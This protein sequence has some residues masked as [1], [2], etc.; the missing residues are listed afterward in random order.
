MKRFYF[1]AVLLLSAT[2]SLH[3]QREQTAEGHAVITQGDDM[4]PNQAREHV[5]EQAKFDAINKTFGSNI[6]HST[7]SMTQDENGQGTSSFFQIGESDLRGTWVKDLDQRVENRVENGQTV[8][9]AWVKGKVRELKRAVVEFK[10]QLLANGIDERYAT[11]QLRDGDA[12]YVR[13]RSPVK[14]YLMLF[15]ADDQG[16]VTLCLPEEGRDYCEIKANQWFLFHHNPN[17]PQEHW[18]ATIPAGRSS[19][20]D[21]LYIVFSPN[22]IFPPGTEQ[23]DGKDLKRYKEKLKPMQQLSFKAFQKY[24]GKLQRR[25]QEVQVERRIVKITSRH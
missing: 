23:A 4:T 21:N 1:I 17:V 10:C 11:E 6:T 19:E 13:F 3:A 15:L 24:L 5:I 8:W 12:W 2:L 18:T 25:D 7:V 9:E 16:N 14:G 22:K 20:T